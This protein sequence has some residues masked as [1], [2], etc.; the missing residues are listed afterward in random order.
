M[1]RERLMAAVSGK[2]ILITGASSGIGEQV[3]YALAG[4]PVRLI[5]VGRREERL[6]TVK[7]QIER[8]IARAE[9]FRADLRDEE[10]MNAFLAYLRGLPDGVDIVVSNAGHSIRR[11]IADTLDRFHDV[12]RTAAIN[13]LAPVRLLLALIPAL[14]QHQGQI[15]HI[16]TINTRLIPFPYWAAYQASKAAFDT[17]FRSAAPEL[18]A[19]GIAA[20]SIYLPLVRTPMIEPTKEYKRMPAMSPERAANIIC[21]TMYTRKSKYQPWWLPFGEWASV[22]LRGVWERTAWKWLR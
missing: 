11:S 4:F 2:T 12:T 3:A 18:Q 22:L 9:V 14:K 21:K 20:T 19:M 7:R 6:L 8:Q 13:Y 1:N 16:S 15:I 5:L 17:W 10:D